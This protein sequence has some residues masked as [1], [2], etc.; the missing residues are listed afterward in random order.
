MYFDQFGIKDF[1]LFQ[2][3]SLPAYVTQNAY[4]KEESSFK[5]IV[6]EIPLSEVPEGANVITSHVLYRVKI[7]DDGSHIMKARIAPHGN[8]DCEKSNLKTDSATCPPVGIRLLLSLASIHKWPI[9]KVDFKSAFLQTG[10]AKRDVYVVPPREC[11]T[12]SCYWLLLT[13][14]YGLVNANAKWQDHIDNFLFGLGLSQLVYVP[15]LFYKIENDILSIAAVKVVDDILLCG[16]RRYVQD[17]IDLISNSYELGTILFG[18]GTIIFFGMTITQSDDYVITIHADDKLESMQPFP[19]TRLRRKEIDDALNDV[20]LSAFRSLNSSIGWMGIA[21]SPFCALTASYLQQ[22]GPHPTVR[23]L[24][25]QTNMLR[26]LKRLGSVIK[27]KTPSRGEYDLSILL[28]ADASRR[29]DHGQIGYLSGLLFGPIGEGATFHLM[30]WTSHKSKRPVKSIG[31]AEILAAG[32][33]IDEGKMLVKAYEKLLNVSVAHIVAVDSKDLFTTLSTCR[34]A[35]DRSIRAD[36]SV[37]RYEFETRNVSTMIWLPG[38]SNL[39]DPLTKPDSP[40]ELPLQLMMFSGEIPVS[41][42]ETMF[43]HSDQSTG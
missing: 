27:F 39:A 17:I 26:T 18:P 29:I 6:K 7:C 16:E 4:D 20:E 13:A 12:K 31:A 1:M 30:S 2:A 42:T 38:K 15:Q 37:I 35:T 43:R 36:V 33:A 10:E 19:L 8:K 14:A 5:K 3:Q 25:T 32:A 9:A 28:F 22:K 24:V 23:D 34:N 11:A 40:L 41:F 21:A